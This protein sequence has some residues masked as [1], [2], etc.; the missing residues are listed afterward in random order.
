MEKKKNVKKKEVCEK[1]KVKK[2]KNE[3]IVESCGVEE[4]E[5]VNEGQIERQNDLFKKIL[6]V[7]GGFIIFFLVIYFLNSS[8]KNFNVKGVEFD[9]DT[10]EMQGVT[11]YHTS[12]PIIYN[13]ERTKYNFWLRTDPRKLDNLVP[14]G[15]KIIFRKNAVF[16]VTTENLFCEGDWTIGLTNMFN[17]YKLFDL[18]ILTKKENE[19]YTPKED[20]MFITISEGNKTEILQKDD[21]NYEIKINN[22]EVLPAFEKMMLE[23]FVR[24][25]NK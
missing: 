1:F 18:N 16:D 24:Y 6:L 15:G 5:I 4:E 20:Y 9:I 10:K 7:M 22:C 11:L 13:G 25:N 8:I 19:T 12:L 2:G 3:A 23:V 21:Y 17:L 14:F